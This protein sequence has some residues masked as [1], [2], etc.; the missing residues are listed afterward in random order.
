M[1]R[2][3]MRGREPVDEG[4]RGKR[5]CKTQEG[6]ERMRGRKPVNERI[7]FVYILRVIF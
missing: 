6:R 4:K 5:E 1:G 2:E 7:F 3:R